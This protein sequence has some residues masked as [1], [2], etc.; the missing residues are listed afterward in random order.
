VK[1]ILQL[2]QTRDG[3]MLVPKFDLYVGRSL[4]AYGDYSVDER[5]L[6]EALVKPGDTVCQV[7]AN[8]GS[9]TIPLARAVGDEGMVLAIEPQAVIFRT[10]VANL[11]LGNHWN[12]RAL[13]AAAGKQPGKAAMPAVDYTRPGNFGGLG[14][15]AEPTTQQ[16][17]LVTIDGALAGVPSL[18]LLH[19]DAEGH[20]MDVLEGAVQTIRRHRPLV[21]LEVDR[22]EIQDSLPAWL[23]QHDYHAYM[24]LPPL[25]TAE[26]WRQNTHN[27]FED[28]LGVQTVSVNALAIPA[29]QLA[30]FTWITNQLKPYPLLDGNADASEKTPPPPPSRKVA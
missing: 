4:Q 21:Y 17:A 6:L 27:A 12:V 11:A 22:P 15:S 9:L 25:Y 1:D 8:I 5:R 18:A 16:V 19:V 7:G 28:E 10:L 3:V 24:H 26:N 13:E 20:E 14:L 2:V 29:E 30:Q 23:A